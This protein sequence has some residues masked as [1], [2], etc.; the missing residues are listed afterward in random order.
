VFLDRTSLGS[1]LREDWS[2]ALKR[3]KRGAIINSRIWELLKGG[4]A[5]RW[6]FTTSH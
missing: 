6:S 1:D 5:E 3:G 2:L 4:P